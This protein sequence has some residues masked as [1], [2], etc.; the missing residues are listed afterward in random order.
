MKKFLNSISVDTKNLL[1]NFVGGIVWFLSI[2]NVIEIE[3]NPVAT[4][5]FK[6]VG[7]STLLVASILLFFETMEEFLIKEDEMFIAHMKEA[8]AK[9]LDIVVGGLMC[10]DLGISVQSFLA[11]LIL[12]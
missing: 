9:T 10:V 4:S 5:I 6:I 11:D 2:M 8:K 3:S 7:G 12:E 1:F